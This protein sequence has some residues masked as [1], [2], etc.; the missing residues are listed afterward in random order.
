MRYISNRVIS[1]SLSI[2][3]VDR[4]IR[5]IPVTKG[6]S[7]Y[8]TDNKEE[9]SA[10]EKSP[11]YGK[12]YK[13]SEIQP[14][15]DCGKPNA[16]GRKKA[17]AKPKMQSVNGVDSWQEAIEYMVDKHGADRNGMTSPEEILKE[18]ERLNLCF[19]NIGL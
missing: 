8:V 6:G 11:M 10:L 9:M 17:S 1:F 19:P 3:G 16:R 4:R 15:G 2:N 5:F 7:I 13:R 12:V 14:E 18:A